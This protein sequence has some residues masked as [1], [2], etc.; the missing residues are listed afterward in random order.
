M[1]AKFDGLESRRCEDIKGIVAPEIRK[2]NRP[3][4]RNL[5]TAISLLTTRLIP[6]FRVSFTSPSTQHHGFFKNKPFID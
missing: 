4:L 6:N 3:Q 1:T 5:F 2:K